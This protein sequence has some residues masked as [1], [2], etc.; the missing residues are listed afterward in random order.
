MSTRDNCR[1]NADVYREKALV[2]FVWH[3]DILFQPNDISVGHIHFKDHI[4]EI[5]AL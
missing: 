1:A 4:Q 2:G 3:P 5:N